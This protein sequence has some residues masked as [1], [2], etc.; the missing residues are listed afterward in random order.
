MIFKKNKKEQSCEVSA[1]LKYLRLALTN[2]H[3]IEEY[4]N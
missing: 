3:L 1:Q 4:T 2:K